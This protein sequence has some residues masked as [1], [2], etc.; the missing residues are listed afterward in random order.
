MQY[1]QGD[2]MKGSIFVRGLSTVMTVVI[3]GQ[4]TL[5]ANLALAQTQVN[6]MAPTDPFWSNTTTGS[7]FNPTSSNLW[8]NNPGDPFGGVPGGNDPWGS[9]TDTGGW[10][11]SIGGG[12]GW[13]D[14]MNLGTGTMG[15][16]SI[17]PTDP[18]WLQVMR[19]TG[20]IDKSYTGKIR[21]LRVQYAA[22]GSEDD[23]AIADIIIKNNSNM[24]A[25]LAA[26][27]STMAPALDYVWQ[28]RGNMSGW[29]YGMG[30]VGGY[31]ADF[32]SVIMEEADM[33]FS[34]QE[35]YGEFS[36]DADERAANAMMPF[37]LGMGGAALNRF[38]S[39]KLMI[40]PPP[41][42]VP[43]PG[44]API[45][46]DPI[47]PATLATTTEKVA[48][49]T[50]AVEKSGIADVEAAKIT[51][52]ALQNPKV[53][54][55]M[56]KMAARL[57]KKGSSDEEISQ[58]V[59]KL[60]MKVN[61]PGILEKHFPKMA[62]KRDVYLAWI[63]KQP[64]L[65][66]VMFTAFVSAGFNRENCYLFGK[67][68]KYYYKSLHKI[69]VA[70]AIHLM[71][72]KQAAKD[73][74]WLILLRDVFPNMDKP[75]KSGKHTHHGEA[76]M[77]ATIMMK[78]L[79]LFRYTDSSGFYRDDLV[80]LLEDYKN[81]NKVVG[82]KSVNMIDTYLSDLRYT[83]PIEG[84][85]ELVKLIY[86]A[87]LMKGRITYHDKQVI[88]TVG[89]GLGLRPPDETKEQ[90]LDTLMLHPEDPRMVHWNRYKELLDY[91]DLAANEE[92]LIA[93]KMMLPKNT[94]F[95]TAKKWRSG[96]L[97]VTDF[98]ESGVQDAA[99][100]LDEVK[101]HGGVVQGDSDKAQVVAN[102][103]VQASGQPPQNVTPSDDWFKEWAVQPVP[104]TTTPAITTGATGTGTGVTIPA[105]APAPAAPV[106]GSGTTTMAKPQGVT[107]VPV[108]PIP[109]PP[110]S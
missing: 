102:K 89:I 63:R 85:L 76:I 83:L 1:L 24:A 4:F 101:K 70:N 54:A 91:M 88:A 29:G 33:M 96:Q 108:A 64:V 51:G 50:K 79:P 66:K 23:D 3:V 30:L 58:A 49:A 22:Y 32:V 80:S 90:N 42:P 56:M 17:R 14:P 92:S 55:V 97:V 72:A 9:W 110:K 45:P 20:V 94:G 7:Q 59:D 104:T 82:G 2:A 93:A 100:F 109:Q 46:P 107:A 52:Q 62:A 75:D 12:T 27:A 19:Y 13:G 40:S 34:L 48:N 74:A 69:H 10:N 38:V 31:L 43:G 39:D 25:M 65:F 99:A 67:W 98:E 81:S 73:V 77:Y 87:M 68:A 18:L 60:M 44:P 53:R 36:S 37:L 103:I 84:Q 28:T 6:P 78:E 26:G 35:L 21:N 8:F 5:G 41:V 71:R 15:Y 95:V 57:A 106:Q 105:P 11:S 47:P 86:G 16:P 61:V